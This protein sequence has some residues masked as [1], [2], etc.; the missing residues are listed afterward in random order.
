[1]AL[2]FKRKMKSAL[3]MQRKLNKAAYNRY[4]Q[5]K[6]IANKNY[7]L[8]SNTYK[9][10]EITINFNKKVFT[11]KELENYVVKIYLYKD[12]K[13]KTLVFETK[14]PHKTINLKN[15]VLLNDAELFY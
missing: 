9:P 4:R 2:F 10:Q 13:F 15:G 11:K 6:T 7:P 5:T 12:E 14:V 3:R 1:M 8:L